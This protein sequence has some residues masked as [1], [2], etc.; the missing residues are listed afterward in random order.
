MLVDKQ[1]IMGDDVRKFHNHSI[2]Q[3]GNDG[4]KICVKCCILAYLI[5]KHRTRSGSQT[6]VPKQSISF[7]YGQHDIIGKSIGIIKKNFALIREQR[8]LE[9]LYNTEKGIETKLERLK[10]ENK[11]KI[12]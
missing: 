3:G 10:K 7:H 5:N 4:E 2:R 9:E 1:I 12:C 11:R 6:Q 8:I